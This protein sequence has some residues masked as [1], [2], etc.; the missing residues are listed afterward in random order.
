VTDTKDNDPLLCIG[1]DHYYFKSCIIGVRRYTDEYGAGNFNIKVRFSK[2]APPVI[3]KSESGEECDAEFRR[4]VTLL[5][6]EVPSEEVPEAEESAPEE[7]DNPCS[8]A[9]LQRLKSELETVR[10]HAEIAGGTPFGLYTDLCGAVGLV[11]QSVRLLLDVQERESE[12]SSVKDSAPEKK[13]VVEKEPKEE[14]APLE[15]KSTLIKIQE[16]LDAVDN[17]ADYTTAADDVSV[18][19]H[20]RILCASEKLDEAVR[21]LQ[22]G[23]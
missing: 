11:S 7:E 3:L 22:G 9:N 5:G 6:G 13:E 23:E 2:G 16:V 12:A 19:V 1:E 21:I 20:E 4:L 17:L 10:T 15:E 18:A 8:L 14:E